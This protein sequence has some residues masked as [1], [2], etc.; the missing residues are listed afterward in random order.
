MCFASVFILG[1]AR[2]WKCGVQVEDYMEDYRVIFRIL[3]LFGGIVCFNVVDSESAWDYDIL[4]GRSI[5]F[6]VELLSVFAH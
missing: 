4:E 5:C 3:F 6:L 1:T 2:V